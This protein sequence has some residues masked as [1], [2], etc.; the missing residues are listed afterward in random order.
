MDIHLIDVQEQP[1]AGVRQRV[2]MDEITTV[3]DTAYPKVLGAIQQA[4]GVP[5]GAPYARY[6]GMP[7][8][9][10]DVEVGF[11]VTEPFTASGDVIGSTLPAARAAEA[12]HTGAY[13]TLPE[14]YKVLEAWI[15]EHNLQVLDESWEI[16]E[17]GPDS[18]P[19]PA[20]WRTRVVFPVSGP[21][22]ERS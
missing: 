17:A 8:D 15:A 1:V 7:S 9:T 14:T 11:P 6:F 2:R 12:V 20:T 4:G 13:D 16:Y 19:D 10:V 22:V 3:F 18:D 5:A 21:Q